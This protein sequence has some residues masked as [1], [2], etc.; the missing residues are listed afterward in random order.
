MI[1]LLAFGSVGFLSLVGIVMV[2]LLV[3]VEY[4]KPALATISL[5]ATAFA[6]AYWGD[7]NLLTAIKAHPLEA[8]AGLA[9]Y[10]VAGGLWSIGKWWF[11]VRNLRDKYDELKANFFQWANLNLTGK[12]RVPEA[13]RA[14]FK[15]YALRNSTHGRVWERP[16][17]RQ[18]KSRIMTWMM[19]WPWSLTWTIISDPVK[20][21]FKAMFRWLLTVYE[22]IA[23]RMYRGVE[24]D[25]KV[26]TKP[27]TQDAE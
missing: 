10:F 4:E 9:G 23:N 1:S 27:A 18:N 20:R 26:S 14:E 11:F 24:D 6:L 8:L 22:G 3:A 25:F 13:S 5:V 12:D 2:L 7:F 17:V 16:M 15:D 21:M 19:Y